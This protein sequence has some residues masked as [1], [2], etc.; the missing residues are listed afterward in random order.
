MEGNHIAFSLPV[1]AREESAPST[2][3]PG[4]GG[5]DLWKMM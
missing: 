3:P 2:R 4:L 5:T 1:Q